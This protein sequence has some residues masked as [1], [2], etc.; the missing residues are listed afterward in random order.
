MSKKQNEAKHQFLMGGSTLGACSLKPMLPVLRLLW[1]QLREPTEKKGFHLFQPRPVILLTLSV[2][3]DASESD[4]L[5]GKAGTQF[6]R[7][8]TGI[9]ET[10]GSSEYLLENKYC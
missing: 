9:S 3:C 4:I 8:A 7:N 6:S 5:Q 2:I 1:Q 10:N